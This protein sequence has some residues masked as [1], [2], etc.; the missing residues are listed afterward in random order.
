MPLL[1]VVLAA[2]FDKAISF[3]RTSIVLGGEFDTALADET[4]VIGAHY[5]HVGYGYVGAQSEKEIVFTSGCTGAINLAARG[6][7]VVVMRSSGLLNFLYL[8]WLLR[9][10]GVWQA[11][12]ARRIAALEAGQANSTK[13]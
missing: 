8:R 13:S 4:I 2:R 7:L 10:L 11:L 9:R 6:S 5:D 1:P 3:A 12:D